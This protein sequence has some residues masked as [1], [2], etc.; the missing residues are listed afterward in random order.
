MCVGRR[1]RGRGEGGGERGRGRKGRGRG[2][3]EVF[4]PIPG[5]ISCAEGARECS[6]S[7]QG[8]LYLSMQEKA[9]VTTPPMTPVSKLSVYMYMIK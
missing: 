5:L 1:G 8:K 4:Q 7:S 3:E 2:R 9:G 6:H